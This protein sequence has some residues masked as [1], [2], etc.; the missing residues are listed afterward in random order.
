[1]HGISHLKGP[2]FKVL[3]IIE[4]FPLAPLTLTLTMDTQEHFIQ[5]LAA[6]N[7]VIFLIYLSPE[8][9]IQFY[10]FHNLQSNHTDTN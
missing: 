8:K 4:T 6:V 10:F 3:G 5:N 7:T 9:Q 2:F 1:M